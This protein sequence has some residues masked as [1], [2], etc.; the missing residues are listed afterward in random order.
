MSDL[1]VGVN[2]L[3]CLPGAVGG[4][5]EYLARQLVGLRRMAPEIRPRLF[6]VPGYAAAHPEL[7]E[8]I[9]LVVAS[10]DARRRSR[11]VLSETTWLPSQLAGVDVVHHGGGTVPLR[12]P[13][14]IVVTVHDLQFLRY[15][16]YFSPL[17]RRYLGVRVP[18]SIRRAAVV[19]VPSEFVKGTVVEAYGTDPDRVVVVPHGVDPPPPSDATATADAVL[20]P[21]DPVPGAVTDEATVRQRY[22]IGDRP[23]V[24]F[25]AITHPHKQHRFLLELL[26]GAGGGAGWPHA[27]SDPDLLLVLLG[28]A[29]MADAEVGELIAREGLGTR[30]RRPG[31]VPAADRDGLIAAAHALV[32]PSR[33]EGFGAPILEAMALGTPVVCSDE[34]AL[35]EV[36]G[37]AAVMVPLD[38]EA[39]AGALDE[40][41]RRR[42]ELVAAGRARA[43]RFSTEASGAALAGAYRQAASATR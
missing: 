27:W 12:S 2:L 16:A 37:D 11:R 19:A 28:G 18:R 15:P 13:G 30:V 24:V 38:A 7:G 8:G 10:L 39:W 33:Y 25:P 26:V 1:T 6:V 32:F 5:E 4:S 34:A 41:A 21:L 40:V 14:P 42:D 17:K 43:E 20:A 36:A 22:G 35:P 29:G 23:F 31:R 9:E 3:W